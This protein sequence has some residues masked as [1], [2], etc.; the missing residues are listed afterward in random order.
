[1]GWRGAPKM[2]IWALVF[3]SVSENLALSLPLYVRQISLSRLLLSEA[4][5]R[6][7]TN[8]NTTP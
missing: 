4:L 6:E 7:F 8:T 2:N 5:P 1:M 3:R